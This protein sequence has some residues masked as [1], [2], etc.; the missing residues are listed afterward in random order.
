MPMMSIPGNHEVGDG[1]QYLDWNPRYPMPSTQ[2]GSTDNTYWSRDIESMHVIGLNAYAG[3][4]PSTLMYKW[5]VEDMRTIDRSRTPWVLVMMHVPWYNSNSGHEGEGIIMQNNMEELLYSMGVD[6]VLNG[7]V[8]AYERTAAVYKWQLDECGPVHLN[9]GDGGNREGAYVPWTEPQPQWSLFRESSFGVAS[10]EVM[11]STHAHYVWKRHAC[12]NENDAGNQNFEAATCFTDNDNSVDKM[13]ASDDAWI[14]RSE[15]CT[16]KQFSGDN[17]SAD[18]SSSGL[19]CGESSWKVAAIFLICF[20]I[21]ALVLIA[22]LMMHIRELRGPAT[23]KSDPMTE[24][25]YMD[26]N[27][28]NVEIPNYASKTQ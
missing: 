15:S 4:D 21:L 11:N 18:S 14:V 24:Y 17:L 8:H 16:N 7:H 2:S 13:V 26:E 5:L 6:I 28:V 19:S 27:P 10:L 1:E 9:L 23:A 3:T 20:L 22:Y 25:H 12:Q